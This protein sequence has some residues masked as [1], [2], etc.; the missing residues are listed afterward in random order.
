MRGAALGLRRALGALA[1]PAGEAEAFA[2]AADPAVLGD[3]LAGLLALAREEILR[4]APKGE[5]S[6]LDTLDGVVTTMTDDVFL[7]ALP[8]LRQAFAF[9]PP[10]ER[11]RVAQLLLDRRNLHGSARTLL[12]TTADPLLLAR[13]AALEE[14]TDLLL[15]RHALGAPR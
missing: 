11:E 12:R 6:L 15:D 4:P 3:W 1:E 13:A 9:F 2:V 7:N 8:A 14:H 10:R 5:Q